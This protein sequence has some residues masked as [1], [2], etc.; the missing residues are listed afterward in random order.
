MLLPQKPG[1]K[2]LIV[3]SWSLYTC[4]EPSWQSYS[5]PNMNQVGNHTRSEYEPSWPIIINR[6][7]L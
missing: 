5:R 2:C 4:D 7:I 6:G 1:D 3:V